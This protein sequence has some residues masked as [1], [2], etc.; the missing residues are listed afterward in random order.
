[1]AVTGQTVDLQTVV[2]ALQNIVVALGNVVQALNQ[3]AAGTV[4]TGAVTS[5][6]ATGGSASALPAKPV[7][8]W[9]VQIPG[10]GTQKIPYYS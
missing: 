6:S 3:S 8:Y 10:V 2:Q 9:T 1:M 4:P 5:T 7:G